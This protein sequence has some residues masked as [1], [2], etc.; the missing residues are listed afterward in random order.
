MSFTNNNDYND[1]S[2]LDWNDFSFSPSHNIASSC[3]SPSI[4]I[5]NTSS[6]LWSNDQ[7]WSNR[8]NYE[9]NNNLESINNT[10][11]NH[12]NYDSNNINFNSCSYMKDDSEYY[13]SN[14]NDFK[15]EIIKL[16]MKNDELKMKNDE[17]KSIN[18][19]LSSENTALKMTKWCLTDVNEI[20][21][22]EKGTHEKSQL[23]K[24]QNEITRKE[25]VIKKLLKS[26][27]KYKNSI[28]NIKKI[29]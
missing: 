22:I 25:T 20:D 6:D 15:Q 7:W 14:D 19:D 9:L 12:T 24:L 10:N 8:C 11:T 5:H 17:L 18:L 3:Y 26:N 4:N 21:Q 27:K 1:Y 28:K 16:K 2:N 29:L 23:V 13:F